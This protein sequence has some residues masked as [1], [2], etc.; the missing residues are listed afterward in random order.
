MEQADDLAR[1]LR[2]SNDGGGSCCRRLPGTRDAAGI[3]KMTQ[4]FALSADAR[5]LLF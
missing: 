4:E 3:A 2:I 1:L 5:A